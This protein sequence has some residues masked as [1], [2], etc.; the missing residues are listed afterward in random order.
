MKCAEMC[1]FHRNDKVRKDK[2]VES[3][4]LRIKDEDWEQVKMTRRG[5]WLTGINILVLRVKL[6]QYPENILICF[7]KN[8]KNKELNL[9]CALLN[10]TKEG[11]G[12]INYFLKNFW[13]L[14]IFEYLFGW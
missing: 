3:Q 6:C 4:K 9:S 12:G 14:F 10:L 13:S 11:V 1:I 7:C 5:K 2:R 8:L